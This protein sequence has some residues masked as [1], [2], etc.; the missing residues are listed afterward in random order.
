[1]GIS[2]H[3]TELASYGSSDRPVNLQD[4]KFG[5]RSQVKNLVSR[6]IPITPESVLNMGQYYFL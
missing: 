6:N 3:K 5:T 4:L 1:M 2:I